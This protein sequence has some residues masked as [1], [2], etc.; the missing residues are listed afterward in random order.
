MVKLETKYFKSTDGITRIHALIWYPDEEKYQQPVG[1]IQISHGMVDHIERFFAL[2]E[3]MA[4]RGFVVVGNDHLGHGDSVVS[5]DKWGY[6]AKGDASRFVVSDLHKLTRIMKKRYPELPYF[7]IGHS[8]GSFMAR[9]YA[10]EYGKELTGLVL[11]GTGNQPYLV[12]LAGLALNGIVGFLKGEQYRSEFVKKIMFGSYNKRIINRRTDNDWITSDD[13]L[14][15][16]YNRDAKCMFTFTVNGNKGLL[17]TLKFIQQKK[18]I[19]RI[20]KKLPVILAAG[21]EDPVGNYGKD[22]KKLYHLYTHY[23]DD[24]K[25]KLYEGCRHEL[26]NEKNK[27]EVLTDL[28]EWIKDHRE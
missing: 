1:I 14:V 11:L 3:Y 22:V 10:M 25:L 8:M 5:Q 23:L 15:D 21:L 7:L 4:E 26:H 27:D 28:Y 19:A 12:V 9:R 18:N 2:A 20:P 6:F 24:V 16:E 13:K 17:T